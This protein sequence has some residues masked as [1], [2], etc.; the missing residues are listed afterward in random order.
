M[1]IIPA[2][3]RQ[4]VED[5]TALHASR[6]ALCGAPHSAVRHL[7]RFDDRLLAHLDGL[8]VAGD[9]G[10]P[11]CQAGLE[12]PSPGALFVVAVRLIEARQPDGLRPIFALAQ[13]APDT[14]RGL[15]SAFGWIEPPRLRG[16]VPSLLT[17]EESFSRLVGMVA[18]AL[19]R[20]DP[21]IANGRW[22][23]DQSPQVRARSLRTAGELGRQE[24]LSACSM[25]MGD[26]DSD[27]RSWAAWSGVLLGNRGVALEALTANGL[28]PGPQRARAYRLALQAMRPGGAHEVLQEVARD[29]Q[30]LRWLIQ[31]TGIVGDGVYAPWL[32]K[33]MLNDQTARLAGEA[34]SVITGADLALL[35]LERRPPENFESGPN[36]DPDDDNVEM[37][38]DGDLPWPDVEKVEKWW[39]ANGSR[40]QSGQRYFMGAPVTR[41]H[42]IKV[43]KNGYQRQR[44][45]A[46]HYLCLL[47]PGTPLFNT[48]APAWRQQRLLAQM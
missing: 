33:H 1:P 41:E 45:L 2:V 20:V 21:G 28:A 6:T 15:L 8:S 22:I 40:F 47:N 26:A 25:A 10:W 48:S 32:I 4:H 37:D 44:I 13:A 38:P 24:L 17:S 14:R 27:C 34:F 19:H 9:E 46:A 11:F 36:D 30:N 23:Q 5:A 29:P 16:L 35:D 18:C 42:C 12:T 43:L 3:V 31:G 7:R 39:A